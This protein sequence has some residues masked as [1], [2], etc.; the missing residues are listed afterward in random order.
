MSSSL[1]QWI[2]ENPPQPLPRTLV[3][4]RHALDDF[5]PDLMAVAGLVESDGALTGMVLQ[6]S[7]SSGVRQGVV[8][9]GLTALEGLLED[10]FLEVPMVNPYSPLY[11]LAAQAHH[12]GLCMA[13]C[14][15]LVGRLGRVPARQRISG[16]LAHCAGLLQGIGRITLLGHHAEY[17]MQLKRHGEWTPAQWLAY[18]QES[19]GFQQQQVGAALC[20]HWGLPEAVVA[21]VANPD[22]GLSLLKA[23]RSV[24]FRQGVVMQAMVGLVTA[25]LAGPSTLEQV[26]PYL[27]VLGVAER[28]WP[29]LL[30]ALQQVPAPAWHDRLGEG[31]SDHESA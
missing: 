16:E 5:T 2:A 23:G 11:P 26:L 9:L 1:T 12:R 29:T 18:E 19:F 7:S 22:G 3:Q 14:A 20:R 31:E 10:L 6:A 24:A 25:A 28:D 15:E 17:R 8:Q 13:C 30:A 27:A 4:L 21:V